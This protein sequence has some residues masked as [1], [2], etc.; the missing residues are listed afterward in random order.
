VSIEC[1]YQN[2]GIATSVALTMFEGDDL[3]EAMG[4]PL[5]YGTVEA[6][7]LGIYCI[8]AWKMGWTKAPSDANFCTMI[9]TSYEVLAA[10]KE[11]GEAIEVSLGEI[12]GC[13]VPN[14]TAS[15][16]M[17]DS[18]PNRNTFHYKYWVNPCEKKGQTADST[19]QMHDTNDNNTST[20]PTTTTAPDSSGA[21]A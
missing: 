6:V 1:C 10:E 8:G 18:E 19:I 4:A 11:H 2:V 15:M 16:D 21:M 9:S 14:P 7:V 5:F 20:I 12:L 17:G 3:A 13:N